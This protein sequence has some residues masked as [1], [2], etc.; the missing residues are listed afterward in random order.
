MPSGV[1]PAGLLLGFAPAS[2]VFHLV[3]EIFDGSAAIVLEYLI[4]TLTDVCGNEKA[5]LAEFAFLV[6]ELHP[7]G[8]VPMAV[9]EFGQADRGSVTHPLVFAIEEHPMAHL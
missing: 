7:H 2:T 8:T 1:A 6:F 4:S 9:E 3:E 5:R